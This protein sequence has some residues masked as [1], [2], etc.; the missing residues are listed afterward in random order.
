MNDGMTTSRTADATT[1]GLRQ[2]FKDITGQ[3][4]G[5]WTV[6]R[7][8]GDNG[9][10]AITWL[11]ECDCVNK[12]RRAVAG[13]ALRSGS[14]TCCGCM[15]HTAKTHGKSKHPLYRIYSGILQRILNKDNKH[16]PGYGGRGITICDR[17]L[18]DFQAFYDDMFPTWKKGLTVERKD[19]NG[20]YSPSNCVW[21]TRRE[22]ACNKRNSRRFIYNGEDLTASEWRR[23]IG[24]SGAG[25]YA[26]I[27]AGWTI[28]EIVTTP[29]GQM[30]ASHPRNKPGP[31]PSAARITDPAYR[32]YKKLLAMRA[33][34][35]H[36][37]R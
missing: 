10:R 13:I 23:R 1:Y 17:W 24:L 4:F 18:K 32:S 8:D 35:H 20:P 5:H 14:S 3:K 36:D 33:A 21:A 15:G 2:K 34:T 11:C 31:K 27:K 16:Y 29:N 12:T 9:Y 26:R 22:Q 6:I 37:C 30:R 28:D 25:F 19:V 7:R